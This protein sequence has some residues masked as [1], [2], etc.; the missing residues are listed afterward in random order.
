MMTVVQNLNLIY[1]LRC[2]FKVNNKEIVIITSLA[3]ALLNQSSEAPYIKT[4]LAQE[5]HQS[6]GVIKND[7]VYFVAMQ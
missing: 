2:S 3:M 6:H 1:H 7:T 5:L 4:K